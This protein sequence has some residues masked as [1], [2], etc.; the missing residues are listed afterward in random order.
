MT[1]DEIRLE[2]YKR[3]KQTK[4]KDIAAALG[5]SPAAVTRVLDG[6]TVSERIMTEIARVIEKP[7]E[8]V[9]PD[10]EFKGTS[11]DAQSA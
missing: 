3:R 2:L 6:T 10:H 8:V 11:Q 1:S 7:R 4:L 5:V 9:W